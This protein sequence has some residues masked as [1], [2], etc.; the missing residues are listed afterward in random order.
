MPRRID[1]P[2]WRGQATRAG[3]GRAPKR[4]ADRAKRT[5]CGGGVR[6]QDKYALGYPTTRKPDGGVPIDIGNP[7]WGPTVL[8]VDLSAGYSRNVFNGRIRWKAQLNVRNAIGDTGLL[9]VTIQPWGEIATTRL[10]P[11]RRWYL[12]N[13]FGF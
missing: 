10:P 2:D 8:N 7:C 9:P 13:T 11:E 12:T 6:W 5:L 3:A 4:E 1:S